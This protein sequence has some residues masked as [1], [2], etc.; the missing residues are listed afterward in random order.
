MDFTENRSVIEF[1]HIVVGADTLAQ[2]ADYVREALGVDVPYGG[3]HP[4][5]GTHNH[6]MRLGDAGFLEIIAIDPAAS[7]AR[8]R[9][10]GL[11]DPV[12]RAR[13]AAKPQIIGWVA[14]TKDLDRALQEI[15]GASGQAIAAARGNLTWRI[16]VPAD[17]SIAFGGAF[18]TLIEW[19][20]GP[21]PQSRMADRL[22]SLERLTVTH[23]EGGVIA[24][25]LAG[26]LDDP[27]I[28]IIAGS[29]AGLHAILRTPSGLR[30]LR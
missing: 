24:A 29:P 2:G 26:H 10:F 5:M 9:W 4:L 17:G 18:P 20:C 28:K 21:L 14:R 7:A 15:P 25:Q 13:L 22:C 30:E 6:L 27:R 3:A 1:D 12:L 8:P 16:G 19:P 23:G 11:D